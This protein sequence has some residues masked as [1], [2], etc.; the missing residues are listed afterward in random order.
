MENPFEFS[1]HPFMTILFISDLHLDES[2]PAMTTLF[3][4]FLNDH[5]AKADALYILGDFFEVWVGDDDQT[6][7]HS[8][9][10]E[11]LKS[12]SQKG[13]PIFLMHGNRDFLL[14]ER[15]AA[16]SGCN[17]IND[18]IVVE[19]Y[20]EPIL[21]MHGDSLCTNDANYQKFRKKTR[22]AIYQKL[23]L[24]LPIK[25]R[26]FIANMLRQASQH[27]TKNIP[28]SIMDVNSEEVKR[29]IQEH[30]VKYLI[31]GHTHRP[32]IEIITVENELKTRIVL[33]DWENKGNALVY[34]SDG[35]YQL[36]YF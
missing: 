33:S 7:F 25:V 19:I 2:R 35:S 16:A 5:A 32:G 6:V 4:D 14:G 31:H 21:L 8:K 12:L 20:G 36:V 26:K 9:I 3:L 13:I 18:P 11:A 27:R 30:H 22:T 34:S 29:V 23:F 1:Y 10:I 17:L 15:F 28:K 24:C